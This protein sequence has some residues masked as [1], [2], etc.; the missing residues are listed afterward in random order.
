MIDKPIGGVILSLKKLGFLFPEFE[1]KTVGI[2]FAAPE[3]LAE[4]NTVKI[5]I[6]RCYWGS[7]GN[8]QKAICAEKAFGNSNNYLRTAANRPRRL[9]TGRAG[10]PAY[11][12]GDI[13]FFQFE[14]KKEMIDKGFSFAFLSKAQYELLVKFEGV[15]E[16]FLS[17]AMVNYGTISSITP[18]STTEKDP[19]SYF[20]FKLEPY[21]LPSNKQLAMPENA[22]IPLYNTL[23][24]CL[25]EWYLGG[26]NAY[27]AFWD[28][29]KTA[30][31]EARKK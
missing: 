16:V 25:I 5:E 31:E 23:Q 14:F 11:K 13:S 24:S 8:G 27:T 15:E 2:A 28:N 9:R 3:S 20:T 26:S 19:Y 21:D 12:E 4:K 10:D 1:P 22:G 30:I 17:G 6:F 7:N 29:L 18:R